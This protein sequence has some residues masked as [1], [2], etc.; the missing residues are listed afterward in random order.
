[1]IYSLFTEEG[2]DLEINR[3]KLQ[4]ERIIKLPEPS[5]A[6]PI[7]PGSNIIIQGNIPIIPLTCICMYM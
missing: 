2:K 1:M 5:V 6:P 3:C 7:H 4:K